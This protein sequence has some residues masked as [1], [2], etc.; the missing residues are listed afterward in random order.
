MIID[1]VIVF[2]FPLQKSI[3]HWLIST[4]MIVFLTL[5]DEHTKDARV[6]LPLLVTIDK[7]LSHGCLDCLLQDERTDFP[8][9]LVMR[10][11]KESSRC[12]DIKRLMATVPVAL[13]ML[14]TNDKDLVHNTIFPFVM[15]LLAHRYPRIRRCTAEQLYVKLL[16]VEE[17]NI[18]PRSDAIQDVIT[19]LSEVIWDTD[20]G[21]PGNVRQSR[22]EVA[23]LLGIQLSEKDRVGPATKSVTKKVED[24]FAS[25]KSLVETAGR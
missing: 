20:L 19:I 5:F 24:E 2:I 1:H 7:V 14:H 11:R 17:E 4:M 23:D 6:I 15:R 22:N 8:K 16:E 21:P 12:S 25:Y 13:G 9:Q 18:V 3:S 10:L